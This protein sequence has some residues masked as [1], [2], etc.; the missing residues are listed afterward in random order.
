[1]EKFHLA[2][3]VT[4]PE[5]AELNLPED[6]SVLLFQSIRELLFNVSKHAGTHEVWLNVETRRGELLI[7]IRDIGAGFDLAAAKMPSGGR[8]SKFG[9]FSIRERMKVL[10]GSFD[11][12]SVPGHGTTAIL[13]LPLENEGIQASRVNPHQTSFPLRQAQSSNRTRTPPRSAYS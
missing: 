1:M 7:Q 4:V 12:Q 3:V 11:I 9:L 5:D 6:Q 13:S 8:S 10:G 2:V